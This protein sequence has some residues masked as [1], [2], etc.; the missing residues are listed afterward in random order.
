MATTNQHEA[1]RH[2]LAL[3]QQT[4][5][6][7]MTLPR[8][9]RDR[10]WWQVVT[11]NVL[12]VAPRKES[13]PARSRQARKRQKTLP[14]FNL[15]MCAASKGLQ[16][17]ACSPGVADHSDCVVEG[18]STF[19]NYQAICKA[20]R[21]ELPPAKL[22]YSHNAFQFAELLTAEQFLFGLAEQD[23]AAITHLRL[24]VPFQIGDWNCSAAEQHA[25]TAI[26]NYYSVPWDRSTLHMG[27]EEEYAMH[28]TKENVYFYYS[29]CYYEHNKH[30]MYKR[31][32]VGLGNTSWDIGIADLRY[33]PEPRIDLAMAISPEGDSQAAMEFWVEVEA[34]DVSDGIL[35]AGPSDWLEPLQQFRQYDGLSIQFYQEGVEGVKMTSSEETERFVKHVQDIITYPKIGPRKCQFFQ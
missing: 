33:K 14:A 1:A 24:D 34:L 13:A 15:Y 16:S 6:K 5:S 21:H 17:S 8:E 11:G 10:I 18:G 9:I 28:N 22:F 27:P 26:C 29:N 25:W 7:L 30:R 35:A 3:E 4:Q 23:R 12:H 20:V 31:W 2:K 19:P 32:Q